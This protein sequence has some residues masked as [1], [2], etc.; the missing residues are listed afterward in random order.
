MAYNKDVYSYV[1][2][3]FKQRREKALEDAKIKKEAIYKKLPELYEIEDQLAETGLSLVRAAF[4]SKNYSEDDYEQYKATFE[5]IK[6]SNIQLQRRRREILMSNGY[7]PDAL[8]PKFTCSKCNDEG[9]YENGEMCSCFKDALR[10]KAVESLGFGNDFGKQ[11]FESFD[12]SY[13]PAAIDPQYGISA[14]KNMKNIFSRC[15]EYAHNFANEHQSLLFVGNTGLGKTFLSAAVARVVAE[16]GYVVI[17]DTAQ[18]IFAAFEDAKFSKDSESA[19]KAA[20][21]LDC[22]LLVI[23][24]LG[25]EFSTQFTVACFYNLLTNRMRASKKMV[26]STN[27]DISS[28][29]TI[30]GA[31]IVSRLIGDFELLQFF[32]KDIRQQKSMMRNN[33]N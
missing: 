20:A 4:V 21:Y 17:Y 22:D 19:E 2:A 18:N 11:T 31:R 30:Y 26:I 8:T 10:K 9:F 1:D 23:D 27:Q 28:L 25:A 32:G 13:Y 3:L 33:F 24:D 7:P 15:V 5:R 14:Q 29:E 6:A 12:L 16:D